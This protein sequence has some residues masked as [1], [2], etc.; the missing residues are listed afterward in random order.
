MLGGAVLV[1]LCL[2]L[3]GTATLGGALA[4]PF[5]FGTAT[6]RPTLEAGV[7]SSTPAPTLAI[8]FESPRPP[9]TISPTP[10]VTLFSDDFS[11]PSGGWEIGSDTGGKRL[12]D[13]GQYVIQ[14]TEKNWL[15][16]STASMTGLS[17]LH[18]E[19]TITSTGFAKDE[20]VGLICGYADT[21]HFYFLAFSPDGYYAIVKMAGTSETALTDPN[22]KWLQSM[23]IAANAA[24]Y[25]VGANCGAD[26]TLALYADG[27]QV[28]SAHDSTYTS[29]EI[30]LIV[31]SFDQ[32]PVEVRFDDLI[33]TALH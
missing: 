20:G 25:R 10:A 30:G 19:V 28:A 11:D 18:M 3:G 13:N 26:G 9:A 29:G 16:W 31:R 23:R 5:L 27:L 4:L 22:G 24:S 21:T 32:L 1:L 15:T 14:V 33:V 2:G 7:A 17:D 8:A 6:T 12:F